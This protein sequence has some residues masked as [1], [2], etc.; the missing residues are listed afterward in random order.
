MLNASLSALL[1]AL[2]PAFAQ[3]AAPVPGAKPKI[4]ICIDD[5][6]LTY[7]KDQPD[8]DWMKISWPITFADM[9]ES[10]RTRQ[11]AA[12]T[13]KRGHELIIHYPFDPFQ[14]LDLDPD[15]AT[16]HDVQSMK[17]LLDKA[18]AEVPGAVGLN[19]H[20]SYRATMNAP[21][22]Q[23]FMG[24]LKPHGVYFLDSR[25]GPKTVAYKEAREAG[26]PT[27]INSIFLDG[28]HEPKA[29]R[30]SDPRV[31]EEAIAEDKAV[32]IH[33]L[34]VVAGMAKKR[35]AAV[36]IGHHYFQGTYQ[37]LMEEVPKLQAE[38]YDFVFLSKLV[39]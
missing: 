7:K 30:S 27:A 3:T 36:A 16:A 14:K 2:S 19:N 32:C 4:A 9:P 1:L 33:Y 31:V 12:E 24:L 29:R 8:E 6:G 35:G 38:G 25:V 10:P 34:R 20:R 37:C 15:H 13:P 39:N 26:I 5:F 22:M 21:L 11:V 18:F 23:A 28:N 17:K